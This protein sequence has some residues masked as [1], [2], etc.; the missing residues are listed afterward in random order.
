M[1]GAKFLARLVWEGEL[2]FMAN[3]GVGIL[4]TELPRADIVPV[5]RA[6]AEQTVSLPIRPVKNVL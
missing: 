4:M 3:V 6:L 1:L 5:E 2:L